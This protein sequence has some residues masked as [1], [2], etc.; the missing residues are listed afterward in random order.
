MGANQTRFVDMAERTTYGEA[1]YKLIRQDL[2]STTPLLPNL[3]TLVIAY[4]PKRTWKE[5]SLISH[6]D[7]H[8]RRIVAGMVQTEFL[9]PVLNTLDYTED[10]LSEWRTEEQ[11]SGISA[12]HFT[13]K[14]SVGRAFDVVLP[15]VL[16]Q[17]ETA[18]I[19]KNRV[20][21]E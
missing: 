8:N 12:H 17:F 5:W 14:M 4:I 3:C 21:V 11:L 10:G 18:G 2:G 9:H 6:D 16:E 13:V 7:E 15:S 20:M 1:E 19:V